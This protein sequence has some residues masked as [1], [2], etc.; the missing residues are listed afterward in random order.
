MSPRL[1]K[2]NS[3]DISLLQAELFSDLMLVHF[4]SEPANFSDIIIRYFGNWVAR[5][6]MVCAMS[7]F[8]QS[9]VRLCSISQVRQMIILLVTI[10]VT[11]LMAARPHTKKRSRDESM[12][13]KISPATALQ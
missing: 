2:L 12:N 13:R 4:P 1:A 7:T 8:V 3:R 10:I 9:V 5:P 6:G 11:T